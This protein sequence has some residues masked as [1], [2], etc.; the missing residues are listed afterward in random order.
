MPARY[1]TREKVIGRLV[2]LYYRGVRL[3]SKDILQSKGGLHTAIYFPYEG[4]SIFGSLAEA[5]NAVADVL[6][7]RGDLDGA[8]KVRRLNGPRE[9]HNKY[10]D[11]KREQVGQEALHWLKKRIETGQDVTIRGLREVDYAMAS[12]LERY[13]GY[14]QAFS[15]LGYNAHDFAKH[16]KHRKEHYFGQLIRLIFR[17]EDLDKP[18]VEKKFGKLADALK[19]H[20]NGYYEALGLARDFLSEKK[21][22]SLRMR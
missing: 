7:Q 22:S 3:C 5:R 11:S 17:G 8:Q 9:S 10:S 1:W 12:K 20:Y 4:G 19:E 2:D 18:T 14:H 13:V 6:E 21:S 16:I 15:E